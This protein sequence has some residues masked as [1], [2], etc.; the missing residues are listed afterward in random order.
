MARTRPVIS[1]IVS[2]LHRNPKMNA[3]SC[4]GVA[5]PSSTSAKLADASADVSAIRYTSDYLEAFEQILA[6][7]PD[8]AAVTGGLVSRYPDSGMLIAA[9]IGPKVAKN[10]MSWG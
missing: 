3:A 7:A 4:D 10:E 8:R 5:L 9:Q 1:S 2:P 6:S